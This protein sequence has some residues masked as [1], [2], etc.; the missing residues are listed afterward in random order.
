MFVFSQGSCAD[1]EE[2]LFQHYY[3]DKSK[4]Y[5]EADESLKVDDEDDEFEEFVIIWLISVEGNCK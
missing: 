3:G 4:N 2:Q 1:Q 5:Q